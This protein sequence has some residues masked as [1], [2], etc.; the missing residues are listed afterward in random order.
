MIA[1]EQEDIRILY[2]REKKSAMGR[3]QATTVL[4]GYL[5][6]IQVSI[7]CTF[8]IVKKRE[9]KIHQCISL[10]KTLSRVFSTE[11]AVIEQLEHWKTALTTTLFVC[12][13]VCLFCTART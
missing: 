4:Y 1:S 2:C 13:S 8:G 5:L 3:S 6:T 9:M 7:S 11:R 10:E 12:C